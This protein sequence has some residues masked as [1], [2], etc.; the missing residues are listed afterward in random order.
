M[1]KPNASHS[2]I[3]TDPTARFTYPTVAQV[4]EALRNFPSNA[5]VSNP[6]NSIGIYDQA[7]IQFAQINLRYD[8]VDDS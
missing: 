3:N 4:M 1:A 5:R 8:N 7:G 2:L 6:C